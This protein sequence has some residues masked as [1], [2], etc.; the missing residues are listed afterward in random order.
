[1]K[2]RLFT[3]P[4]GK[5]PPRIKERAEPMIL[6]RTMPKIITPTFLFAAI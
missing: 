4:F 6:P 2:K 5:T 3:G 1:L